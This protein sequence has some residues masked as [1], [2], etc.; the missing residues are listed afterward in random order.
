MEDC[1]APSER[2]PH[3]MSDRFNLFL[4]NYQE[5][6]KRIV[7]KYRYS[8]HLLEPEEVA[9]RA[10]LSLLKK[11]EDI[12]YGYEGDFDKNAFSRVAYTYVRNIIGWSHTKEGNDKYVKNRLNSTHATEDGPKTSFEFAVATE[13]H[14]EPGFEA[15]D[16]NDK[17]TIL[18]HVIKEYC[19]ILTDGEL[20][21]LSCLE[22]GMTHEQIS[23]KFEFTRQAVSHCAI[24]LFDKIKA[25]FS[26]D[27]LQDDVSYKV[28]EGNES[29]NDF[30]SS[31]NGYIRIAGN[32]K[33]LLR[34]FLLSNIKAY[35]SKGVALVLFNNKY[36]P[37]QIS[38]FCVKNKMTFCL[39]PLLVKHKFS[40]KESIKIANLY[41]EGKN[42]QEIGEIFNLS[43]KTISGK[44]GHLFRLG[45]LKRTQKPIV[46]GKN[47]P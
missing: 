6:I 32:D 5:D 19:H 14:E 25:H 3:P 24:R 42:A 40:E 11:R 37:N 12:L 46:S 9:S 29:I 22:S 1:E 4:Q 26:S 45:L 16:S 10:N 8:S 28:S 21:I 31:K 33:E 20:K 23:N 30:F 35:D 27:V 38:S 7:G 2:P 17:F 36:K 15:F 13:G 44:K 47:L 41:K 34:R 18:L 39:K 43:A